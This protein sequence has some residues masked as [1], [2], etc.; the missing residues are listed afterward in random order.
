LTGRRIRGDLLAG[1]WTMRVR[2]LFL[3]GV[4]LA[5]GVGAGCGKKDTEK[6]DKA[7]PSDKAGKPADKAPAAPSAPSAPTK[8][9]V[10][11]LDCAK[12]C[13][14]QLECTKKAGMIKVDKPDEMV[15]NCKQGCDVMKSMYDPSMHAEAAAMLIKLAAG[16]CD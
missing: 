6:G 11:A 10:G 8:E 13:T 5:V 15:S 7:G 2:D 14:Q 16:S 3:V 4:I 12:A 1:R 9:A